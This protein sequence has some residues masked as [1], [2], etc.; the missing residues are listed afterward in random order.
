MPKPKVINR[1]TCATPDVE[2]SEN[3]GLFIW[4]S[5]AVDVIIFRAT[6]ARTWKLKTIC[7]N[8]RDWTCPI[9]FAADQEAWDYFLGRVEDVGIDA[10]IGPRQRTE[11][12][13]EARQLFETTG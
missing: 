1:T 11:K 4:E 2:I 9:D 12:E 13:Q 3:S 5:I 10:V 6:G 8:A 7:H